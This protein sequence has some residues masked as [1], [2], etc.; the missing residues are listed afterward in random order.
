MM[1]TKA[2]FFIIHGLLHCLA[3]LLPRLTGALLRLLVC[4]PCRVARKRRRG[5]AYHSKDEVR[6]IHDERHVEVAVDVFGLMDVRAS[7]LEDRQYSGPGKLS[8]P[9]ARPLSLQWWPLWSDSDSNTVERKA[10][11][12]LAATALSRATS[13]PDGE[14]NE[15]E[16]LSTP[17]AGTA[18]LPASSAEFPVASCDGSGA[19]PNGRSHEQLKREGRRCGLVYDDPLYSGHIGTIVAAFRPSRSIAYIREEMLAWDG[20]PLAMDWCYVE[21]ETPL[22]YDHCHTSRSHTSCVEVHEPNHETAAAPVLIGP[23]K[24]IVFI[25]PG[26]TSHSQS[27]YVQ[28]LVRVMQRSSLHVCVL[29]TRGMG[30]SPPITTPFLFNGAYTCDIRAC[31]QQFFTKEAIRQRI[32]H[33]LPVIGIGLSVGGAIMSKYVGEQGIAGKDC[34]LDAAL[35]CC[36]PVDFVFTV[37]HM[38]RNFL[39]KVIYQPDMCGDIR[40]YILRHEP[41]Q[42]M[43]NVDQTYVF[44]EGNIH[45]F[46][47]VVHFDQH[48]IAKSAGYR[49]L[50]HYHLDASAITWVP[51]TP[52]PLLVLST[53]DDPVIGPTV[54]P[55]RWSEI[56]KNNPRVVYAEAPVGGHLGFLSGPFSELMEEANWLERF[57][58]SR[59]EAICR[60]WEAKQSLHQ[61]DLHDSGSAPASCLAEEAAEHQQKQLQTMKGDGALS[62]EN[63]WSKTMT[64]ESNRTGSSAGQTQSAALPLD[65]TDSDPPPLR[66]SREDIGSAAVCCSSASS[67]VKRSC[68]AEGEREQR[69]RGGQ[70]WGEVN[71]SAVSSLPSLQAAPELRV[72]KNTVASEETAA[73]SDNNYHAC[74]SVTSGGAD[75]AGLVISPST[76]LP[77]DDRWASRAAVPSLLPT[78]PPRN[79]RLT[80]SCYFNPFYKERIGNGGSSYLPRERLGQVATE[81]LLTTATAPV[82]VNCTYVVDPRSIMLDD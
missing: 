7:P 51:Y 39:Q 61:H 28:R 71:C 78:R 82:V 16:E 58:E 23:A 81:P 54:M 6:L 10:A 66:P 26:L 72:G 69:Q 35:V 31:L 44:E 64:T 30:D 59:A 48:L 43:P 18:A 3:Y 32:G 56:V 25:I 1:A 76:A 62:T 27:N 13:S 57:L 40:N 74:H 79:D 50:H 29:N 34:L 36:S 60:W 33:V 70:W 5:Y 2:V 68:V 4:H 67:N 46:R 20:C 63:E 15:A 17:S 14:P 65:Y 47:R 24:G 22:E 37:E 19:A 75:V 12:P 55:H 41:L 21:G 38:N 8:A 73:A 80:N 49:S 11:V 45:R 53:A 52:I 9:G 42:R 77:N